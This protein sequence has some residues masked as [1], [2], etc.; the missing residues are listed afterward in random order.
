MRNLLQLI[1]TA[2]PGGAETVFRDLV[3]GFGGRGWGVHPVVPHVDWLAE[4]LIARGHEPIF[5]ACRGGHDLVAH[6]WRLARLVRRRSIDVIHA[7]L[8]GPSVEA[9]LLGALTGVPVV[10]TIHGRGDLAADERLKRVKFGILNRGASRVVF[11]SESLR[12]FFLGQGPL[13]PERTAVVANGIDTVR[14]RA[15]GLEAGSAESRSVREELGIPAGAGFVVGAVGNLRPVK[16]YDILLRAAALLKEHSADYHFVIV[17]Q[18]PPDLYADLLAL[19]DA[20][21]LTDHVQFAGFREDI[22][23][24]FAAF[25]LFTI[26]SD[27]EGFSIATVQAM[28]S[29]L[30]V[31]A[32]RCGGP[33]EILE[34]GR[35]GVL[36]ETG[37]PEHLAGAVER[38]RLDPGTRA[39][40]GRAARAE[41]DMRFSLEAQL[42]SYEALYDA[43]LAGAQRSGR[44]RGEAR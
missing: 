15:K 5:E 23:R 25:D 22:E 42:R 2:G 4:Q 36:V 29:G 10:C 14:Y 37:S 26:T 8:W 35:T 30:P 27:S 44:S 21:G 31:V 9:S 7:H 17:G 32:T 3:D 19:R 38:L 33:E 1:N 20:L 41:A 43:A 16:R 11:V 12:D 18:T 40:L 6:L 24:V 28:A 13:R 34:D 39:A